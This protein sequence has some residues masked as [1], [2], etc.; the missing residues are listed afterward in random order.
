MVRPTFTIIELGKELLRLHQALSRKAVVCDDAYIKALLK[1]KEDETWG[2]L[3]REKC[4]FVASVLTFPG[5][6]RI[7]LNCAWFP[8]AGP[9]RAR[10]WQSFKEL[11][12]GEGLRLNERAQGFYCGSDH[13]ILPDGRVFAAKKKM[14]SS[15]PTVGSHG[16]LAWTGPRF[17]I[18]LHDKVELTEPSE[19]ILEL[20][21]KIKP[22][23]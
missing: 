19:L 15:I 9:A 18:D 6:D 4:P 12:G 10:G 11:P 3:G 23:E 14:L 21:G 1:G 13:F 2:Y 17:E 5:G 22:L 16:G 20:Y 8:Y 7:E